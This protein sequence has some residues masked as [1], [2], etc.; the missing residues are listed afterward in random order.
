MYVTRKVALAFEVNFH[1]FRFSSAAFTSMGGAEDLNS[2]LATIPSLTM[3]STCTVPAT[4]AILAMGGY[5]GTS[6]WLRAGSSPAAASWDAED[7]LDS[8]GHWKGGTFS[9]TDSIF[10]IECTTSIVWYPPMWP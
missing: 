3:T 6:A 8:L 1:V 4:R 9:G 10:L 5:S 7:V 2:V